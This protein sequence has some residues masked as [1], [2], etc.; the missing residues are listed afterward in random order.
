[1]ASLNH[2][3]IIKLR[4]LP[5]NGTDGFENGPGGYFLIIDRLVETLGDRIQNWA[6]S[7]FSGKRRLSIFGGGGGLRGIRRRSIDLLP[8]KRASKKDL[9]KSN[10]ATSLPT[11]TKKKMDEQ[12]DERLSVGEYLSA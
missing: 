7:S 5:F 2:P 1:M 8:M 9:S 6:K 12:L 11:P 3:H 10:F 4:G